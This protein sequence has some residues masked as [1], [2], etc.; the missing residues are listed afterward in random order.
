[1]TIKNHTVLCR[2][3]TLFLIMMSYVCDAQ[4]F[5]LITSLYNETNQQ[6]MREYLMCLELNLAH[7]TINHIHIIYDT[8][9]DDKQ[10]ILLS[11][12]QSK[13]V[14]IT[15]IHDRPTFGFCFDIANKQYPDSSIILCNADIF[16]NETLELLKAYDLTNKFLAC[17]RWDVLEDGS[18]KIFA[19]YD[20]N[21][22]FDEF[23]S[24]LSMD[25]WI[26]QTPLR[27]FPNPNFKLG[28]WACDGYI[29]CQA[30]LSGLKVQNPCLS[31]QCCHMHLTG[32]RHWIPQSVPGAKAALVPW[33][34]LE[35]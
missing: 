6:R 30:V 18:L 2:L 19:Q 8:S 21:N 20:K 14:T 9:K 32:I 26:F 33:S 35:D 11:Y 12:L 7:S 29:A 24:F 28:T 10:N 4:K 27:Q 15:Y 13:P 3:L 31:I 17:T 16:F 23:A 1:M 25:A 22:N 34:R 5:T